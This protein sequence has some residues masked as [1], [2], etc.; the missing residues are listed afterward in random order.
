[1]ECLE[2][3]RRVI[4]LED[5]ALE[6]YV[7]V[8]RA[9][10]NSFGDEALDVAEGLR[11]ADGYHV[12]L[13]RR[14]R[15]TEDAPRAAIRAHLEDLSDANWSRKLA[16]VFS[17]PS[18]DRL[19]LV[20]MYCP[21]G[22]AFR[23]LGEPELGLSWCAYDFGYTA[24]LGGGHVALIEPRHYH[25]G[26]AYC[27]QI[28]EAIAD[29][30]RFQALM[31]PELTGWRRYG[32]ADENLSPMGELPERARFF[33]D[34]GVDKPMD[35]DALVR[36]IATLRGNG[37]KGFVRLVAVMAER[38]GDAVFDVVQPLFEAEGISRNELRAS[39]PPV[40]QGWYWSD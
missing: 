19:E 7:L 25:L 26:D 30:D 20:A 34:E 35:R 13:M 33:P 18:Q 11:R 9:L 1:M 4:E 24:A 12:G 27:F 39:S 40:L 6:F 32:H 16:C 28:H 21:V 3:N 36:R 31:T 15:L 5:K 14:A 17:M 10:R 29:P 22:V 38:F 37:V 2:L 23:R 8:M